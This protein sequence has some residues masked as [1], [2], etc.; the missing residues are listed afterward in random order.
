MLITKLR[1]L[2]ELLGCVS[3]LAGCV[4]ERAGCVIELRG[5]VNSAACGFYCVFVSTLI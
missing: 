1:C 4:S 3:E 5:C 2:N